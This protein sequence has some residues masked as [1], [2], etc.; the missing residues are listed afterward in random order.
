MRLDVDKEKQVVLKKHIHAIHCSNNLTLV[1]RKLF[2]A[3]LYKAYSE[4]PYKSQFEI[5]TREL[6]KM[7]GYNSNDYKALKKALLGLV[8]TAVHWNVTNNELSQS[9]HWKVSSILASA[10]L[11]DGRCI[12]EY[13]TM[14][15]NLFYQ[16]EMYG[17]IN[18]HLI[19]QFKSSY[20]LALY[21]NCIRYQGLPQTPWFEIDI[22]RVLMG[23]VG[24]KY[25]A[26]NDFKKRVLNKAVEEV[27]RLCPLN[28]TPE[29]ERKN[30]KVTRVRFKLNK[31][32]LDNEATTSGYTKDGKLITTLCDSFG[33][34]LIA[35]NK[36]L[37]DYEI[38][39]VE[40]KVGMILQ[41]DSYKSGGIRALAAYL[42]ESLRK[43]YKP[44]VS[45]KQ[46]IDEKSRINVEQ[47]KALVLSEKANKEQY[48][49]FI[50]KAVK[51]YLQA[52]SNPDYQSLLQDFVKQQNAVIKKWY[53]KNGLEHAAV[54]ASFNQFVLQT[55]IQPMQYIL[56]YEEFCIKAKDTVQ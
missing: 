9:E 35:A 1:Q 56:S 46:V 14:I 53:K 29:V 24:N 52:I 43:D 7:I 37:S 49:N 34:S 6:C 2:N 13:S 5:K 19:A 8:T 15:K 21:E 55:K 11:Y 42:I 47:E 12:Y 38:D 32:L 54:N 4:L 18:I 50:K 25:P 17:R 40:E 33:F 23:V 22:F 44:N 51:T 30:Q 10:E 41:S 45:S 48:S 31:L 3:L 27:N 39:Y 16:P 28:I 36:L 20:A 26:F